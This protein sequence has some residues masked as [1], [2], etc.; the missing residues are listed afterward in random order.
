MEKRENLRLRILKCM[1]TIG[2]SLVLVNLATPFSQVDAQN[3]PPS[4]IATRMDEGRPSI[5]AQGTATLRAEHQILDQPRIFD[6]P[7]ALRIIGK[8]AESSV[9]SNPQK[10]QLLD[11][12]R[13]FVALRSRYTED[14]L[15]QAVKRGVRQY[16]ILGAGL[17]TFPYRNLYPES[18]LQVFEV[19][20]PTTQLWKRTRLTE[21]GIAIPDSLTFVPIDFEKQTLAEGLKQ[22]GFKFDKPAFFSLLG[23]VMYLTKDA[24]MET[25]RFVTSLP[26]GS[27][28]V[29]DY[30]LPSSALTERQRKVRKVLESRFAAIG[31]PWITYFD[32]SS[33][34]R[35]LQQLGFKNFEDLGPGDAN[36]RYFKDRKDGLHVGGSAHLMKAGF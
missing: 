19:D 27:E 21:V 5:T 24:V 26:P 20:H 36:D 13:A 1:F 7:L 34:V 29:F 33:L 3:D 18:R 32:P 4:H 10:N 35:E 25:L 28:I 22:V 14:K 17:D 16:V 12:L 6:D 11:N 9:R 8:Q 31:E 15:A 23:V 30:A 2:L